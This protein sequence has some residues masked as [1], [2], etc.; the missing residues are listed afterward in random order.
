MTISPSRLAEIKAAAEAAT[1][2][3]WGFRLCGTDADPHIEEVISLAEPH[4]EWCENDPATCPH[5]PSVLTT[6]C[7]VYTKDHDAR[8]IALARTAVPELL[9][10]VE[11]LSA[12]RHIWCTDG[13]Q[14]ELYR[15]AFWE[16][17]Q[18]RETLAKLARAVSALREIAGDPGYDGAVCLAT[19]TLRELGEGV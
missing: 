18:H 4:P 7:N 15:A 3:P 17:A 12:D 6:D 1:P 19:R 14:R 11:R 5:G 8:F 10:E 13:E 2:G 9:A 16:A